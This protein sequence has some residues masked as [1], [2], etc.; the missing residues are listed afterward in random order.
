[1]A[2]SSAPTSAV[3]SLSAAGAYVFS[4][5]SGDAQASAAGQF[6][7]KSINGA[8]LAAHGVLVGEGTGAAPNS[9]VLSDAQLLIGQTSADPAAKT[10]SGDATLADTGALTVTKTGGT[11]FTAAATAAA[12][13]L[14]ATA[15]NDN[16]S[17]GKLGEYVS[18]NVASGSAIG[19]TTLTAANLTSLSLTA[20]DWDVVCDA[21]FG[22]TA[23]GTTYLAAG[24]S[25]SSATF[26]FAGGFYGL[27]V[28]PS[29]TILGNGPTEKAGP[30]RLSLAS[31]TTVYG[32]VA[33]EFSGGTCTAYGLLQ[34][35]RA[36]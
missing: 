30:V 31:T 1:M 13:Q 9:V 36:R 27:H 21:A 16:A 6:T 35:R 7:V 24:V 20:G 28:T 26:N 11:A 17:A 3:P 23:T 5:V 10:V 12:G 4:Q 25:T 33:A 22:S 34:A 19:L 15:T 18:S 8:A 29:G 2:I 32:V 14:P